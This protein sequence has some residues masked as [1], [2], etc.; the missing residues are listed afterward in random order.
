[1]LKTLL[2]HLIVCLALA[3]TAFA[4][5]EDPFDAKSPD[6]RLVIDVSGSMKQNDPNNLRTPAVELL[7]RLLPPESRAGVWIFGQNATR[8][9][10]L[11]KTTA[12]WKQQAIRDSKAIHSNGLFTHIGEALEKATAAP[13]DNKHRK[14]VILLTDGMVDI[15]KDP[16]A[17]QTERQRIINQLLPKIKQE[18]FTLHTIALSSNADKDLLNQLSLATNGAAI[19]AN[20]ADELLQ[21]FIQVLDTAAPAQQLPLTDNTF[22]VDDGINELT[23]LI[24]N[25]LGDAPLQLQTPDNETFNAHNAPSSTHWFEGERYQL[26]T[27][28]KPKKGTWKLLGHLAEGSRVTVV[29][30]LNLQVKPLPNN[31]FLGYAGEMSAVLQE[32]G[33]TYINPEFLKLMRF[34]GSVSLNSGETNAPPLWT[35]T[36]NENQPPIDGIY[37][38]ELPTL[39]KPGVYTLSVLADG[40]TFK[41]EF[42]QRIAVRGQFETEITPVNGNTYEITLKTFDDTLNRES[43]QFDASLENDKHQKK[44]LELAITPIEFWRSEFTLEA[45][46]EYKIKIEVKGKTQTGEPFH[47]SLPPEKIS[48]QMDKTPAPVEPPAP[49]AQAAAPEPAPAPAPVQPAPAEN[50][51]TQWAIWAGLAVGNILILGAFVVLYRKFIRPKQLS[52]KVLE[53][54]S[55]ANIAAPAPKPAAAKPAPPPVPD[56][57]E[58]QMQVPPIE[59][60]EPPMEDLEPAETNDLSDD[61]FGL[62]PTPSYD[63]SNA[64]ADNDSSMSMEDIDALLAAEDPVI[65]PPPPIPEK[66][67]AEPLIKPRQA[68]AEDDMVKAMLKAQGLDLAE[69][70]MDGAISNL[71]DD[72]ENTTQKKLQVRDATPPDFDDFDDFGMD[73]AK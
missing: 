41:R 73:E 8:L 25:Q 67:K 53:E 62:E 50:P 70:E 11:N 60:E 64:S 39:D 48:H 13:S 28:K 34:T 6:V 66:T 15:S 17:N 35:A 56:Y 23:A 14:H 38:S 3:S 61:A 2:F 55:E 52:D 43:L 10:P 24:F 40:K 18:G 65:P 20:T 49:P 31:V 27:L 36:L 68:S 54:F 7:C 19:T 37:K 21:A 4:N 47:T 26:I 44:P 33:K 58:T 5:P 9:T 72:M 69:E 51:Y 16:A 57:D 59:E 42:R 29:S 46:G 12:D 63:S 71:I 22:T 32:D 45:P 1:M 30:D